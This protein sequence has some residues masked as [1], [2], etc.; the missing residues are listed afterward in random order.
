VTSAQGRLEALRFVTD[1][2]HAACDEEFEKLFAAT[3]DCRAPPANAEGHNRGSCVQGQRQA[4]GA[5]TEERRLDEAGSR[6]SVGCV[7]ASRG[8]AEGYAHLAAYIASHGDCRVPETLVA[9][10]GNELGAWVLSERQRLKV[11]R[12]GSDEQQTSRL[13]ALGLA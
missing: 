2:R 7:G 4:R 5:S 9:A 1:P 10:N 13:E 3:C 12:R 6:S 11:A 8:A